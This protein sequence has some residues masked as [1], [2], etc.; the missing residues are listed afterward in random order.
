MTIFTAFDFNLEDFVAAQDSG[1]L[2]AF[3]A[4]HNVTLLPNATFTRD[5]RLRQVCV[6][7]CGRV[8]VWPCGR[9]CGGYA[10]RLTCKGHQVVRLIDFL[11]MEQA[12]L[13]G[14]RMYDI[15]AKSARVALAYTATQVCAPTCATMWS[16]VV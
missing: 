8:A 2:T 4:S 12:L 11:M 14:E 1:L 15:L 13:E 16:A 7:P 3:A 9:V 6:W 5:A 10:R